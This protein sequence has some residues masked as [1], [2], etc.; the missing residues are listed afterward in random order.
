MEEP[1]SLQQGCATSLVAALDPSIEGMRSLLFGYS[2]FRSSL[3]H[4]D[5]PLLSPF[6]PPHALLTFPLLSSSGPLLILQ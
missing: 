5:F 1:K 6:P 3:F 2:L 4:F